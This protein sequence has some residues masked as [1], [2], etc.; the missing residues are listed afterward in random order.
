MNNNIQYL[1][2]LELYTLIY[3][4]EYEGG[5]IKLPDGEDH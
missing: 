4:C 1:E 5:V 2:Y 3:M